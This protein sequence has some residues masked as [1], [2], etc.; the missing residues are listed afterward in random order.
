[1]FGHLL[2]YLDLSRGKRNSDNDR[3]GLRRFKK[4]RFSKYRTRWFL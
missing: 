1:V 3:L 2:G 4:V